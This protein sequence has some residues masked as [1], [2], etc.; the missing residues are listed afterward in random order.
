MQQFVLEKQ[1]TRHSVAELVEPLCVQSKFRF[2]RIDINPHRVF[3]LRRA[4]RR[5]LPAPV[6]I[7]EP[8][9]PAE[10]CRSGRGSSL[11]AIDVSFAYWCQVFI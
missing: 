10:W 4:H 8:R 1:P 2:P 11:A 3:E 6:Q 9:H 5:L 7:F